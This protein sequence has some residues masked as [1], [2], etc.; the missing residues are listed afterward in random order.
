M[1]MIYIVYIFILLV[2]LALI[3]CWLFMPEW[4]GVRFNVFLIIICLFVCIIY[5]D[6][7]I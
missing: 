3:L 1:E 7:T 5:I 4:E 2:E 6:F